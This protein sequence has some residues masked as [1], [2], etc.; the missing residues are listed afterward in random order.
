MNNITNSKNP[1][2]LL[3]SFL[4]PFAGLIVSLCHWRKSWAK[5]VFWLSCVY[6]GAVFIFWP[7][8][9]TLGEGADGGRY[10]LKMLEIRSLG[11]DLGAVLVRHFVDSGGLDMY[12]PLIAY[13]V[14]QITDNGHVLFA[15]LAFVYGFFYS[16]NIWYVLDRIPEK[17][18]GWIAVL[19]ILFFITCPITFI[20]G[21][22]MW[23]ALH[24]YVYALMPYLLEKDRSR[25]WLLLVTPLVHF[26]FLI[27]V[28]I[29]FVYILLPSRIKSQNTLFMKISLLFF[30]ASMF[31]SSLNLASLNS[32]MKGFSPDAYEN[33]VNVY[34]SEG[35]ADV[36]AEAAELHNWYVTASENIQL[37]CYNLLIIIMYPLIRK[38]S[39]DYQGIMNL[40]LFVLLLGS[41]ANIMSFVPS[42]GRFQF[43]ATM[44]K[45]P[46][47]IWVAMSLTTSS[48][49][50]KCVK[51]AMFLLLIPLVFGIRQM[52]DFLS[53]TAILGNFV[54][55]FF[56]ENN[57]PLI[58]YV[59][60]ML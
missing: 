41:A 33:K 15:V 53:V 23:T 6:L 17:K 60:Q 48:Y 16:R 21:V 5:N 52:F 14:S 51:P 8:G 9:T 36:Y 37:W 50:L 58:E 32:T 49:Y 46:L 28:A 22:R 57:V 7:E 44:F 38:H 29:A 18:M 47:I 54:S 11:L 19:V 42:G 13:L 45:L 59:K 35:R 1:L 3:F 34:V 40:Y 4:F 24:I 56:W 20:N 26:S 10:Y 25:L 27:V 2:A 55:V 12:F 43:L 30:I 31:V 39:M